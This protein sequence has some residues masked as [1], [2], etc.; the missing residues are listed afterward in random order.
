MISAASHHFRLPA[1]AFK[2][3]S[4]TFIIRSISA[5][6]TAGCC[7]ST[8]PAFQTAFSKRTDHVLIRPDRSHANNRL[9][10]L[11]GFLHRVEEARGRPTRR[12]SNLPRTIVPSELAPSSGG[13]GGGTRLQA[14]TVSR[15]N[16]SN[17][18]RRRRSA[19][20]VPAAALIGT[21]NTWPPLIV[22]ARARPDGSG[23]MRVR[24][25]PISPLPAL[26]RALRCRVRALGD[27][28]VSERRIDGGGGRGY[29]RGAASIRRS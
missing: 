3:T 10:R 15:R 5:A 25:R 6:G 26:L 17:L 4:C 21:G 28:H 19:F 29:R 22:G 23:T 24:R 1:I 7:F 20:F 13:P 14:G 18:S 2:I 9:S 11:R 8:L 27:R 12:I 16:S